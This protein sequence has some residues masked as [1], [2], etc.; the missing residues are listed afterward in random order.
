MSH[1]LYLV[2]YSRGRHG[3]T[4]AVQPYHWLFFIQAKIVGGK[5]I[6]ITHQLRG[7]PGGF[8][9]PGPEE[10]DFDASQIKREEVEIGQVPVDKLDKVHELLKEIR[11]EKSETLRWN[12]QDWSLAGLDK[13]RAEGFVDETYTND[14]IRHWLKEEGT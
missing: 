12:C 8:Y 6:G 5:K 1:S 9:Y 4:N 14:V 10:I 7:M 3:L 11:I 13:L 2:T